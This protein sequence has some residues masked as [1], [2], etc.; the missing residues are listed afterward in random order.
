M[1]NSKQ[2]SKIDFPK[3]RIFKFLRH[4]SNIVKNPLPFHE[5]NFKRL[6]P[7]FKLQIGLFS[8]VIFSKDADF[9][10]YTLQKN[11]RNYTKSTIQ[12]KDLAKYVGHGL[13]T[14]EGA[15]WQR[16]RKLIQPAFHKKQLEQ[17]LGSMQQVIEQELDKLITNTQADIFPIFNDLAFQTVAKTL[18]SGGVSQEEVRQLQTITEGAQKM[19]V[20]ELRQPFKKWWFYL[21]GELGGHLKAVAKAREV[22]K[23]LVEK[24]KAS[25]E[26]HGDLLDMLLEAQYDDGSFMSEAQLIDEILILFVAGHETTSNALVFTCE[27]L[28]RHPEVFNKV[29][30]EAV[31]LNKNSDDLLAVIRGA[32]YT[33]QVIQE[34]M[35]LYP[36]AYFIDRVNIKD[37]QFGKYVVPKGAT[38]LFSVYE[39]HR[40]ST[41]WENPEAFIPERFNPE[42]PR[43]HSD[44]YF[45]FGA[46]PR[47]CIGNN[48]AMYEMLLAVVHMACNFNIEPK[49]DP[50]KIMPLITLKPKDAI[51]VFSQN[52][53]DSKYA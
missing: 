8:W 28:A 22:L 25:G 41:Y 43:Q 5:E 49:S 2:N 42:L 38:I 15:H 9:L 27:L 14:S 1:T 52:K 39:I 18:F 34:A 12:T 3:V 13:L 53:C 7:N 45:P 10:R 33:R 19:L 44:Y 40:S 46:G 6:G 24:R 16:Q 26:K 50:I 4:A 30:E 31:R 35:R 21:S 37:D 23:S 11:Q 29:Q 20:K 17:L 32:T 51:L 48:F 36:P 47:M